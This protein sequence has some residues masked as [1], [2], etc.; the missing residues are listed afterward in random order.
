VPSL[1]VSKLPRRANQ[2][3]S[4]RTIASI[5]SLVYSL[6]YTAFLGPE[7]RSVLTFVFTTS[8]ILTVVFTSGLSMYIR[9]RHRE[10]I[11]SLFVHSYLLISLSAALMV[12]F[13]STAS[14]LLYANGRTPLPS[15]LVFLCFLY[16]FLSTFTL[17][18]IDCLIATG[19][20]KFSMVFDFMLILMQF[21]IGS[22]F[23]MLN[24]TSVFVSV[25]VSFIA[26]YT[27]AS[28]S[29]ITL[30]AFLYPMKKELLLNGAKDLV[31]SSKH[32]YVVGIANGVVDRID[33]IVIGVFLPFEILGKYALTSGVL[34]FGRFL[35]EAMAKTMLF[36]REN[37]KV[38]YSKSKVS[39][40]HLALLA[41][42]LFI[43][44]G[45]TELIVFFFG[46][47]WNL[48]FAFT[49]AFAFQEF[50]RGFY[51]MSISNMLVTNKD[52]V[53]ASCARY[54]LILSIVTIPLFTFFIGIYGPSAAL[55]LVYLVMIIYLKQYE[56]RGAQD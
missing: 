41:G 47:E 8:M 28:F 19:Q 25:I 50:V 52:A 27:I 33:R 20:L 51:Q 46:V 24:Q 11:N 22:F 13:L 48:P 7:K 32:L 5:F 45:A 15:V 36:G 4:T 29:I 43:S 42:T 10:E 23:I 14:L 26:S 6:M 49:L 16:S 35:P 21:L 44:I 39:A 53:V 34:A 17:S 9:S 55:I 40:K 1:S 38:V 2:F 37:Q 30:L 31:V 54:L 18:L 3:I 12:S 56:A